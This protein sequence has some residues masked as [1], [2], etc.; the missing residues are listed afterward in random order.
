M[1]GPIEPHGP[2]G[3]IWPEEDFGVWEGP[4]HDWTSKFR[5]WLDDHVKARH[6]VVQAGGACGMYPRLLAG[7]FENVYTFE[8][9]PVNF[10]FLNLNC[11]NQNV[12]KFNCALGSK[13]QNT[14]FYPPDVSNR[15]VGNIK[16]SEDQKTDLYSGN[17]PTLMIDDFYFKELNLI[18]LD[19][20]NYELYALKGSINTIIEHKPV[21]ICESATQEIIE[22]LETYGYFVAEKKGAD[23]LFKVR[24]GTV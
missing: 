6:T 11:P 8:P 7:L 13:H 22:F 2:D 3:W 23:T 18:F 5:P 1:V 16:A 21:I 17:T 14:T 12:K 20:E 19:I 15:G 10:Y 9:D 4:K 24:D